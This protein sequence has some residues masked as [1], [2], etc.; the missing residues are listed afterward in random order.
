[1]DLI[2]FWISFMNF[3]CHCK[4]YHESGKEIYSNR[5]TKMA[6]IGNCCCFNL[7]TGAMI[8]SY[9]R[10]FIG[11]LFIIIYFVLDDYFYDPAILIVLICGKYLTRRW[12]GKIKKNVDELNF[13]V[14]GIIGIMI[15]VSIFLLIKTVCLMQTI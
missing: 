13:L 5:R 7:E 10:I 12:A 4:F 2:N 11:I 15:G 3:S 1:M 9:L 14:I 8:L 6:R